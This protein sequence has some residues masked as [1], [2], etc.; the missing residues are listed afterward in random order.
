MLSADSAHRP[1]SSLSRAFGRCLIEARPSVQLIFLL[2]FLT[3]AAVSGPG[4][5]SPVEVLVGCLS[6]SCAMVG[7]YV[8]N[9]IADVSED[10]RNHK[11]RPIASGALPPAAALRWCAGLAA[12]A[13]AG[14]AFL[15]GTFLALVVVV[16]VLGYLY[17]APGVALKRT[18]AGAAATA[19]AGG[20]A[21]VAAGYQLGDGAHGLLEPA[22]VIL[23]L[24]AWMGGVGA[25][26]KDYSD[27]AGDAE[28]GRRTLAVVFGRRR[29]GLVGAA[30]ALL[31]AG[32]FLA[33]SLAWELT[34][35][36]FPAFLMLGGA[37]ILAALAPGGGSAVTDRLPYRVFMWTQYAVTISLLV[38]YSVHRAH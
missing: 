2:R 1:A 16:L 4:T 19:L 31:V 32:S 20:A 18:S 15:D 14:G 27:I 25:L 30:S 10:R 26:T 36:T 5:V 13:L 29:A 37:A 21:T 34:A 23:A 6:W 22:V 9:G 3:G 8:F 35:T 28:A 12:V 17:S 24:S 7:I 33:A 38:E 11:D